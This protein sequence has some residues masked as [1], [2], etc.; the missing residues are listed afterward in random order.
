MSFHSRVSKM[1]EF[2]IQFTFER[3]CAKSAL[4]TW[5]IPTQ[6]AYKSVINCLNTTFPVLVCVTTGSG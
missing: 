4:K 6:N 5:P 1:E 3:T 2:L